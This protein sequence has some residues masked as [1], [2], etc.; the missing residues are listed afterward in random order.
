MG[1]ACHDPSPP[2]GRP[3]LLHHILWCR[4]SRSPAPPPRLDGRAHPRCSVRVCVRV[5]VRVGAGG[6]ELH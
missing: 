1:N 3:R 6:E 2:Q 5:R 4:P